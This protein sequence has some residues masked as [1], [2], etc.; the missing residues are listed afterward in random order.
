M[1]K[2]TQ[3]TYLDDTTQTVVET[4]FDV[5]QSEKYARANGWGNA[6]EAPIGMNAYTA[7]FALRRAH[8]LPDGQG[9]DEW[10]QNVQRLEDVAAPDS[11]ER[12]GLSPAGQT[13]AT[14]S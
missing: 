6:N 9:F 10:V 14:A 7:Y 11:D 13:A 3:V 1:A 2:Q 12:M 8:Q 5:M 4:L